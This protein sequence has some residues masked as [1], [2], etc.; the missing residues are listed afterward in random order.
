M[1]ALRKASLPHRNNQY[2]WELTYCQ[3]GQQDA[4]VVKYQ[5]T[6]CVAKMERQ[7]GTAVVILQQGGFYTLNRFKWGSKTYRYCLMSEMRLI[8]CAN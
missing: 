2:E 3:G 8:G 7:D 6:D 4:I 5:A 1:F